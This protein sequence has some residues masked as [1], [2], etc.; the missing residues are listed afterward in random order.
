MPASAHCFL[1]LGIVA[2]CS[3]LP[4][5]GGEGGRPRRLL[6]MGPVIRRYRS[7]N[8]GEEAVLANL[9]GA[10]PAPRAAGAAASM[11]TVGVVK[12][13]TCV[14]LIAAS[15]IGGSFLAL[16]MTTQPL[17]FMPSALCMYSRMFL[18]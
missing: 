2:C 16:P 10:A 13:L 12:I 1:A 14:A 17:G 5:R 4:A 18:P 15:A 9:R 11:A 3:A 7:A 6:G 8:F